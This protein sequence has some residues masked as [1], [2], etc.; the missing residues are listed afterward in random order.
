MGSFL[1]WAVH[2]AQ[3][4]LTGDGVW[5][6]CCH[7]ALGFCDVSEREN[8]NERGKEKLDCVALVLTLSQ[9]CARLADSQV[10]SQTR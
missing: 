5:L 9:T 1:L 8:V 4:V 10:T 7:R 3:P 2:P 6:R